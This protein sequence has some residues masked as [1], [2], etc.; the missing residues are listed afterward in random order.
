VL[1]QSTFPGWD[2][3]AIDV[4]DKII[5]IINQANKAAGIPLV[6]VDFIPATY[7]ENLLALQDGSIDTFA[8]G[9]FLTRLLRTSSAGSKFSIGFWQSGMGI[10][11]Q[12]VSTQPSLMAALASPG[13]WISLAG[14]FFG[15]VAFGLCW[16][17]VERETEELEAERKKE[18]KEAA[19]AL[20]RYCGYDTSSNVT[21]RG[22]WEGLGTGM[23]WTATTMTT[24]GYGDQAPKT[25]CG[26]V[27][28]VATMIASL[29]LVGMF[30]SNLTSAMT[31]TALNGDTSI[32]SIAD[33][34]GANV[35]AVQGS[36]P[37][38]YLTQ[39]G[40]TNLMGTATMSDAV[41]LLLDGKVTAIVGVND[42]LN[43]WS[44]QFKAAGNVRLVGSQY[45]A[46]S[47][48]FPFSAGGDAT[49]KVVTD[50]LLALEDTEALDS[51]VNKYFNI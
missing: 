2:G 13:P 30:T 26:R 51:I 38:N 17:C 41:D 40:T 35:A 33:L 15:L 23:W 50:A 14:F 24:V 5:A 29:F 45:H 25:S 18:Q 48:V 12:S 34:N 42:V 21:E 19:N 46:H 36:F 31:L 28:S 44:T 27:L 1:L 11:I 4:F 22:F 8:T 47:L 7:A 3:F 10:M 32:S 39:Q 9:V 16:Y 43:Y 6:R 49:A 37:Y 20:D